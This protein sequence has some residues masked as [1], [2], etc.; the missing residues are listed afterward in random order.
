MSL[1]NNIFGAQ[2]H[3]CGNS[4]HRFEPR[5]HLK[6]PER[7]SNIKTWD[8]GNVESLKEKIYVHDVCVYCG[9]VA[10]KD[11]FGYSSILK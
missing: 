3:I 8:G 7:M 4:N 5:Y 9:K 11:D 2:Y 10:K 6:F 1:F